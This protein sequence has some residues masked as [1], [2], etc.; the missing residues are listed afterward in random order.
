MTEHKEKIWR[1][2]V[3]Y[4]ASIKFLCENS[5]SLLYGDQVITTA[6]AF[7][8]FSYVNR[9]GNYNMLYSLY[10]D[11]AGMLILEYSNPNLDMY[12]KKSFHIAKRVEYEALTALLT[13]G[14][15]NDS[16]PACT[17]ICYINTRKT[18]TLN[19]VYNCGNIIYFTSY[20]TQMQQT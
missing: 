2:V 1:P 4:N 12:D 9:S 11:C 18:W 3:I 5:R 7:V 6:P 16:D 15:L 13:K 8:C 20:T 14:R 10:M 17:Q 19:A